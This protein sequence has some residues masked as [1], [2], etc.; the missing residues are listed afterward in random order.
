MQPD[1]Y[2]RLQRAAG[3]HDLVLGPA[4]GGGGRN[5]DDDVLPRG[6]GHAYAPLLA[7]LHD[8]DRCHLLAVAY[9]RGVQPF[10]V[11]LQR[12]VGDVAEPG[13]GPGDIFQR[14]AQPDGLSSVLEGARP[15]RHR[16]QIEDLH[17]ATGREL[18]A[19]GVKQDVVARVPRAQPEFRRAFPQAGLHQLRRKAHDLLP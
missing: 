7:V 9:R 19:V 8:A 11:R 5:D 2:A 16:A 3:T 17:T 12:P 18:H 13:V 14:I 10:Q 6:L 1:R 15:A 4:Q